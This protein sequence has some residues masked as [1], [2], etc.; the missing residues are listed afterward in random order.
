[1]TSQCPHEQGLHRLCP[2]SSSLSMRRGK[3]CEGTVKRGLLASQALTRNLEL[4]H[5]ASRAVRNTFCRLSH[6][7]RGLE[8]MKTPHSQHWLGSRHPVANKESLSSCAY[9]L[10]GRAGVMR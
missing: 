2:L 8:L 10:V 4:R 9:S 7:A 6:V 5:P 1:M 3:S